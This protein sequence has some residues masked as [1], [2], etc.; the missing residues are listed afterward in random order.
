MGG[1]CASS[2]GGA[3]RFSLIGISGCGWQVFVSPP[4][5]RLGVVV[6][7]AL[8]PQE[9]VLGA[10]PPPSSDMSLSRLGGEGTSLWL[11]GSLQKVPGADVGAPGQWSP[12]QPNKGESSQH[13][14]NKD[15]NQSVSIHTWHISLSYMVVA[16]GADGS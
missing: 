12:P 4:A 7:G 6:Q 16:A 3:L 11:A 9:R 5:G 13:R 10:L 2:L 8:C 1:Q 15:I 14:K